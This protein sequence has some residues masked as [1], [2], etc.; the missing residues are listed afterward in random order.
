MKARIKKLEK[1]DTRHLQAAL[2]W[3]ELSLPGWEVRYAEAEV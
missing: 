3:L 2:G 1:P